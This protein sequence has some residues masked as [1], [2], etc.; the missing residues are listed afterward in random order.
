MFSSLARK[1]FL[2]RKVLFHDFLLPETLPKL[3]TASECLDGF[4]HFSIEI[5]KKR[6]IA[7]HISLFLMNHSTYQTTNSRNKIRK[8]DVNKSNC[9][10]YI[11]SVDSQSYATFDRPLIPHNSTNTLVTLCIVHETPE[12]KLRFTFNV[13][14]K[15]I[16]LR[17]VFFSKML[18]ARSQPKFNGD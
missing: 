15:K 3:L 7:F 9:V 10:T 11:L 2:S 1:T 14:A 5:N 16:I 6:K 8:N 12:K 4:S 18:C 17:N 13:S